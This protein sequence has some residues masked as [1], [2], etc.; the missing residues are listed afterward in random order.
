MSRLFF[1]AAEAYEIALRIEQNGARF[2]K[3]AAASVPAGALRDVL[4]GLGAMEDDHEV[5]FRAMLD[6]I[7]DES[8][9]P[10]FEPDDQTAL[11]LGAL[12]DGNVFGADEDFEAVFREGAS[13]ASILEVALAR[14]KDAVVFFSA[15]R[16]SAVAARDQEAIGAIVREEVGHVGLIG[17]QI[18]NLKGA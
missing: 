7:P 2:Y 9:T 16:E 11:Y 1:K 8:A 17:R 15:L 14:E 6:H 4:A 18:A 10:V 12:A 13:P 3:R 5:R